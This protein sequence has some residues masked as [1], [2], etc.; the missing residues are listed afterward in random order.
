MLQVK[1]QIYINMHYH[2]ETHQTHSYKCQTMPAPKSEHSKLAVSLL[3]SSI[4]KLPNNS[5][6]N[7][8]F[9]KISDLY[10]NS[11]NTRKSPSQNTSQETIN[12]NQSEAA[13]HRLH[14]HLKMKS[15]MELFI[16]ATFY[17]LLFLNIQSFQTCSIFRISVAGIETTASALS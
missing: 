8:L 10:N 9:Q 7:L 3:I 6:N 14:A 1:T 12:Q 15:N 13:D 5:L 11:K 17:T 4:L 2:A 16:T